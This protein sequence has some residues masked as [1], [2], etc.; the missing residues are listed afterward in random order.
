MKYINITDKIPPKR[1]L[2]KATAKTTE[3]M[4]L[5]TAT[6]RADF[7]DANKAIWAELKNWL[8]E[9]SNDKCWY[10]EVKIIMSDYHVDHFRPKKIAK[11][12]QDVV[13]HADG[14]WWLSFDWTNYRVASTYCNCKRKEKGKTYGKGV[15]L[16]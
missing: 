5:Q 9:L 12:I 14:Y 1:W 7:I 10:S 15:V 2:D 11:G 6:A 8:L 16:V 3:M 4:R 13:H